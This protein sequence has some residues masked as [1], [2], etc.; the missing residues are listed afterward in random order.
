MAADGGV[1]PGAA[2][3]AGHRLRV[4]VARD[5]ARGPAIGVLAEDAPDDLGLGRDDAPLAGLLGAGQGRDHRVP[6]SQASRDAPRPGTAEL[7]TADLFGGLGEHH[8]R[9]RAHDG[10]VHL[11]D[12]ALPYRVDLDP[13]EGQPVEQIGDVGQFAAEPVQ[14][15]GKHHINPSRLSIGQQPLKSRAETACPTEGGVLVDIRH[16]PALPLDI[17][18]AHLDL[19]G[20][21]GLTL[22]VAAIAG[23]DANAHR[24]LSRGERGRVWGSA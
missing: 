8:L 4:E 23:V 3:W 6:V 24:G 19:I 7:A 22:V 2:L 16:G 20:N 12:L 17:A 1:D 14:R 21:R 15:F 5:V 18:A 11:G 10:D 9:H 13:R